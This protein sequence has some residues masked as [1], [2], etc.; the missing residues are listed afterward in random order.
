[1]F[2]IASNRLPWLVEEQQMCERWN[3]GLQQYTTLMRVPARI[4]PVGQGI[5]QT[6]QCGNIE[7]YLVVLS[8]KGIGRGEGGRGVHVCEAEIFCGTFSTNVFQIHI[9]K[10]HFPGYLSRLHASPLLKHYSC[11][12]KHRFYHIVVCV[13][14]CK[15][16][17]CAL[18][19]VKSTTKVV[20]D[21]ATS[22]FRPWSKYPYNFACNNI[23]QNGIRC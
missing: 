13:W 18:I 8:D 17:V 16:E 4:S 11:L 12:K 20:S 9:I 19:S 23:V 15:C 21:W 6:F 7:R 14:G 10:N 2:E 1:M 3:S 22:V 5:T